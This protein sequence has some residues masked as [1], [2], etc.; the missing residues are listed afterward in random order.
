MQAIPLSGVVL[1]TSPQDLAGMVVAKAANMSEKMKAPV[2]GLVENMSYLECPRCHE[3]IEV[4]GPSSATQAA[5]SMGVP[6]LGRLPLDPDL[7]RACDA[8][9]IEAY[10][11]ESIL[12]IVAELDRKVRSLV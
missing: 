2:L 4:F 6:L 7:A 11:A 3:R 10:G 1:V 12:P 8:G 5:R 9:E